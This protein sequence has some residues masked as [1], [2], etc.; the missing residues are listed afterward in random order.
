VIFDDIALCLYEALEIARTDGAVLTAA[1]KNK[2]LLRHELLERLEEYRRERPELYT[3]LAC[4]NVIQGIKLYNEIFNLR[5]QYVNT[6]DT[7]EVSREQCAAALDAKAWIV[8]YG[9]SHAFAV[10]PTHA[11]DF[12]ATLH[13][14]HTN[15]FKY[16][17]WYAFHVK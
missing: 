12:T 14:L 17:D 1:R 9:M 11:A 2:T 5:I 7:P 4:G 3:A 10:S 6:V 15:N 8:A 13:S 16:K